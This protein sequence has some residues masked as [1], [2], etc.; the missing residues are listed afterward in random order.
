MSSIFSFVRFFHRS[1]WALASVVIFMII[2]EVWLDLEIP[3]Y[4][5]S[6]TDII[7]GGGTT[8]EVLDEAI[9][10]VMCAI[11]SMAVGLAVSV[12]V[13]WISSS[14][15]KTIRAA[16]FNHIQKFSFCEIDRISSY[17]LITRSTNDVKQVQDFIGIALESLIRA[18]IIS[19]WAILRISQSD[20][21][22]TAATLT[23]IIAMV[24]LVIT[25]MRLTAP[26]YRKVQTFH[27]SIN[28]M[29]MEMLTGQ[30]VI[31]AYNADELER[32]KFEATNEALTENNIHALRITSVNIPLNGLIR[33]TLLMGIY[34]LGAFI[35]MGTASEE[36]RLELF[37][38]MI[39]FS[40]YALMALNGFRTLVQIFNA[41][42]RAQASL[43]RIFEVMNTE[44]TI[45][46]GG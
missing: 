32:E 43:E 24:I 46:S 40:T 22:W 18:P 36:G 28:A 37:S 17:S 14:V 31:R 39:V 2:F 11:G 41:L 42:P 20:I 15:A 1:E 34:W 6:I 19:I 12:I 33:N 23:A 27:D 13:G 30:R 8:Q 4:M 10:M 16:E 25:V 29:T 5:A 38:E 26:L 3:N 35:I 9:P 44:P 21:S 45:E 7:T